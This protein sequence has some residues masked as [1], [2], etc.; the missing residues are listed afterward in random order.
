MIRPAL[1]ALATVLAAPVSAHAATVTL[2]V[3][4][5]ASSIPDQSAVDLG[6][7]QV[8][9]QAPFS[10]F[11]LVATATNDAGAPV[12]PPSGDFTYATIDLVARTV[13]GAETVASTQTIYDAN[14]IAFVIQY[15]TQHTTYVARL[16][17][18]PNAGVAAEA[19]SNELPI[20]MYLRHYPNAFRSFINRTVRFSG[21]FSRAEGVDVRAAL[22]VQVQRR[23]KKGWKTVAVKKPLAS[24]RSWKA[25]VTYPSIPAVFRVRVVPLA[26]KRYI[27]MIDY[28][29]CV[30]ATKKKAQKLCKSV[31]FKA[32]RS[33]AVSATGR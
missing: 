33:V 17:P 22:R 5:A 11:K 8:A 31:K 10:G 3:D 23:T 28:A 15:P 24:D 30:A 9:F 2:S 4:N 1:L 32:F 6:G 29:Y 21:F 12:L 19:R 18:A 20:L 26:P 14:P 13:D 27:G 7:G 25:A 16:N